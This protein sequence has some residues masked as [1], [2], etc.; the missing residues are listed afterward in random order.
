MESNGVPAISQRETYRLLKNDSPYADGVAEV[1]GL[2]IEDGPPKPGPFAAY[3]LEPP[4]APKLKHKGIVT[5]DITEQF[6]GA[7]QSISALKCV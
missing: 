5:T 2:D 1:A 6:I 4:P 7:A 3:E